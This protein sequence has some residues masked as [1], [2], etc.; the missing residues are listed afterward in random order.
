MFETYFKDYFKDFAQNSKSVWSCETGSVLLAAKEMYEATGEVDYYRN[1]VEYI[2]FYIADDGTLINL[3]EESQDA[4]VMGLGKILCFLYEQDAKEKYK[5]ALDVL[6][7]HIRS[8]EDKYEELPLY[9]EFETKFNQKENYN[10]VYRCMKNS[11]EYFK[12]EAVSLECCAYDLLALIDMYENSSEEVFEQHK[13]YFVW[14]KESL[15]AILGREQKGIKETAII[16]YCILKGCRLGV[17]LQEKYQLLGEEMVCRLCGL[18]FAEIK[19]DQGVGTVAMAYAE[20]L[21]RLEIL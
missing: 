14:F 5:K 20:Y 10:D 7:T 12:D 16:A 6:V 13:Q 1:I 15:K 11:R 18:D 17:L 4:Y 3:N 19:A 21:R 8:M 2:N 9:L